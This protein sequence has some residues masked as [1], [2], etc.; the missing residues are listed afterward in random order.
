MPERTPQEDI[1]AL[2]RAII[3]LAEWADLTTRGNTTTEGRKVALANVLKQHP[4]ILALYEP[5]G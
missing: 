3:E 4:V 5:K 1:A 2:R